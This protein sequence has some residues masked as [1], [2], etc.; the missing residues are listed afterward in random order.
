MVIKFISSFIL[1]SIVSGAYATNSP[2]SQRRAA[3]ESYKIYVKKARKAL[4][5][6]RNVTDKEYLK[7]ALEVATKYDEKK[8]ALRS[9]WAAG[10]NLAEEVFT[11][12][13]DKRFIQEESKKEFLRR[14]TWLYPDDGCFARADLAKKNIYEFTQEPVYKIFVFGDLNVE[15]ANSPEGFVTWWF[16]VAPIIMIDDVAYVFDP[17]INPYSLTP[18]KKWLKKMSSNIE[19]LEIAICHANTYVP[20]SPCELAE[21]NSEFALENQKQFLAAEWERQIELGRNP[22]EVLGEKPIWK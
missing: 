1:L 17:A 3:D 13:R 22:D 18:A 9:G 6:E 16:H 8:L 19:Q 4:K 14:S 10:Q 12:I 2:V 15:T 5:I 7:S 11:Q 21:D 20:N